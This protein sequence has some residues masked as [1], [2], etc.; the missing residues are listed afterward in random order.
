[1]RTPEEI[2]AHAD[3]DIGLTH[4]LDGLAFLRAAAAIVA[5]IDRNTAGAGTRLRPSFFGE[6][7]AYLE[8]LAS[9]E[10]EL[11]PSAIVTEAERILAILED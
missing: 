1:M 4:P 6:A 10:W 7:R 9:G 11:N 5:A 8:R 2:D 3:S